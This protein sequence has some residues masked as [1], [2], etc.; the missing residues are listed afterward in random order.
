MFKNG[1]FQLPKKDD[2]GDQQPDILDTPERK[3][4]NVFLSQ[5]KKAQKYIDLSLFEEFLIIKYLKKCY[6]LYTI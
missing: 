4:F 3:Q 6:K 1:R 5:I 2:S